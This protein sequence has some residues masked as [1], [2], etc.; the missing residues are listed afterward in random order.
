MLPKELIEEIKYFSQPIETDIRK[1]HFNGYDNYFFEI[2]Q[3]IVKT[4]LQMIHL[5]DFYDE[6]RLNYFLNHFEQE[7][8][9]AY[10]ES[11]DCYDRPEFF[12]IKMQNKIITIFNSCTKITLPLENKNQIL[13]AMRKYRDFIAK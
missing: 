9:C 13:N 6:K 2:K 10:D 1:E 4:E 3:G 8:D 5:I 7:K 11:S 12:K